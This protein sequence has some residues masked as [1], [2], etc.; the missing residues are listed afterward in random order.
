MG[1]GV[2]TAFIQ[3][4]NRVENILGDRGPPPF[5]RLL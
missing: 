3:G 2:A 1:I 4:L 5:S